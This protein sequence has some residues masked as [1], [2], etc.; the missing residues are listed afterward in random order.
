MNDSLKRIQKQCKEV[1]IVKLADRIFN[2]KDIPMGWSEEK[3]D[4][5]REEAKMILEQIG[6]YNEYMVDRLRLKIDCYK[7]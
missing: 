5:Y 2:L 7:K 6:Y 1:A 4:L 3:V